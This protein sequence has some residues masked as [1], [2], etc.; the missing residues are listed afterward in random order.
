ML[1]SVLL[2][3]YTKAFNHGGGVFFKFGG[4]ENENG[5][6]PPPPPPLNLEKSGEGVREGGRGWPLHPP[7]EKRG[8]LLLYK[9][10]LLT[11]WS[12]KVLLGGMGLRSLLDLVNSYRQG[13]RW[14]SPSSLLGLFAEARRIFYPT[15]AQISDNLCILLSAP[16]QFCPQYVFHTRLCS[17]LFQR[18]FQG[19]VCLPMR[20]LMCR[21]SYSR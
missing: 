17:F 5:T 21:P 8:S 2:L 6:P 1:S 12:Q 14:L 13:S 9:D 15:H 3:F 19:S 20:R 18:C 11:P 7:P 16:L 4:G 10:K